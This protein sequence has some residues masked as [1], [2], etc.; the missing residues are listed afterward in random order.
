MTTN[1]KV[2]KVRTDFDKT[3]EYNVSVANCTKE[4]KV[5]VQ[6]AFFDVGLQWEYGGS[7]FQFLDAVMYTNTL[8]GGRVTGYCM[9]GSS[10]KRSNMLAEEFLDL[11]YESESC[12]KEETTTQPDRQHPAAAQA[13]HLEG[14]TSMIDFDQE[15]FSCTDGPKEQNNKISMSSLYPDYFKSCAGLTELDVYTVHHLFEINDP[16]GCIQ[17]ASKKLLLSGVRTGGKSVYKD[18]KEARDT[19]TRK[20]QLMEQFPEDAAAY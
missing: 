7:S 12:A 8:S 14:I 18:I 9:F 2:R 10:T 16:S 4:E 20:L 3:K 15:C 6:R 11:V 13:A 19:L 17:H 5:A 1:H